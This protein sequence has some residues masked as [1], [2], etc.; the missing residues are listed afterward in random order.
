MNPKLLTASAS[1]ANRAVE[2]LD[3]DCWRRAHS[4][5]E[6]SGEE[7]EESEHH[8]IVFNSFEDF[9]STGEDL[10]SVTSFQLRGS[11]YIDGLR[12]NRGAE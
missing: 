9:E 2:S 10:K 8:D 11:A 12:G 5:C 6:K 3:R 7:E 4:S 1:W